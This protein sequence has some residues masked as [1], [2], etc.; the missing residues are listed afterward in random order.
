M[1][2]RKKTA[3]KKTST[4][5]EVVSWKEQ[6]AKHAAAQQEKLPVSG[7]GNTISGRNGVFRYQGEELGD[8]IRVVVLDYAYHN[9]YYD[10]PYDPDNISA[11]ACFAISTMPLSMVPHETAPVPQAESCKTCWANEFG[12]DNRGRGK[13]CRQGIVMALI[14]EDQLG[15]EEAEIA[16]LS[17]PPKS[18]ANWGSFMRPRSKVLGL[19]SYAFIVDISFDE[20]SDYIMYRFTEAGRVPEDKLGQMVA[21]FETAHHMVMEAPDV[22]GYEEPKKVARAAGSGSRVTKKFSKKKVS[23]KR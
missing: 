8:T 11:Q 2:T 1:A 12:T 16:L 22:S 23:K 3:S 18:V 20:D 9:N 4:S 6:L 13:A 7:S 21:V 15:A 14:S 10:R 5:K 17:L 19:P